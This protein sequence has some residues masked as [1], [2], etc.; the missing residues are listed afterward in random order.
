MGSVE[1]ARRGRRQLF[2]AMS[3]VSVVWCLEQSGGEDTVG[4][5]SREDLDDG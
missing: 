4:V 3:G 1:L 5:G 2:W